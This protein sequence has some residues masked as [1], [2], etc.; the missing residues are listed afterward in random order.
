MQ[1]YRRRQSIYQLDKKDPEAGPQRKESVDLG[2]FVDKINDLRAEKLLTLFAKHFIQVAAYSN[3]HGAHPQAMSY[4]LYA[5]NLLNILLDEKVDCPPSSQDDLQYLF[6]KIKKRKNET[7][8]GLNRMIN[9]T[10]KLT[11]KTELVKK[12]TKPSSNWEL[13]K[14]ES[15]KRAKDS[16]NSDRSTSSSGLDSSYKKPSEPSTSSASSDFVDSLHQSNSSTTNQKPAQSPKF[17]KLGN[18]ENSILKS[19]PSSDQNGRQNGISNA[20]SESD[21]LNDETC[22]TFTVFSDEEED[23]TDL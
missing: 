23:S 19:L 8:E 20:I 7:R 6:D 13:K 1:E 16:A 21:E 2:V 17:P 5:E 3:K 15:S 10:H 14:K 4:L 9:Y 12:L 18:R 22:V 11:H